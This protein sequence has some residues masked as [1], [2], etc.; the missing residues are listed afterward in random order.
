M[1]FLNR[2]VGLPVIKPG[3]IA[4]MLLTCSCSQSIENKNTQAKKNE[5]SK[6]NLLKSRLPVLVIQLLL[7]VS[8]LFF[9]IPIPCKWKE[10]NQ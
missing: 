8:Q 3:I 1:E 10:L 2:I 4:I 7:T 6:T 9:I 5:A